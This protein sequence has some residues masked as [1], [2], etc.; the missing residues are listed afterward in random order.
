M[1][2]FL[3]ICSF[4]MAGVALLPSSMGLGAT[5]VMNALCIAG[6][7]WMAYQSGDYR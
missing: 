3:L 6:S 4:L 1:K 7:I 5:T 2:I